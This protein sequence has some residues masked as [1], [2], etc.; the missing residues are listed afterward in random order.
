LH[1]GGRRNKLGIPKAEFKRAKRHQCWRNRFTETGKISERRGTASAE[2]C[3]GL[4]AS[5]TALYQD[6][7]SVGPLRPNKDLAFR[8]WV[9]TTISYRVPQ[10]RLNLAQ[11]AVLGW[12]APLKSPAGTTEKVIE[13]W[14]WVRGA[15][16]ASFSRPYGTFRLSNLYPGLR[17]GLSSAVPAGL[18]LRSAIRV[19]LELYKQPGQPGTISEKS[20]MREKS[21]STEAIRARRF[22][23]R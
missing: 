13:T 16:R 6:T 12:N 19:V 10:G 11:D 8:P 5:T 3:A 20:A 17:P 2:E 1:L 7:S 21:L 4:L 14:S 23:R 9:R 15:D 22:L 18:V